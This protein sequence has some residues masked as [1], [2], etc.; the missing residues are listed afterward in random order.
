MNDIEKFAKKNELYAPKLC[1]KKE[2]SNYYSVRRSETP[3]CEVGLPVMIKET[4]G[5][6]EVVEGKEV[7]DILEEVNPYK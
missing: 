6:C 4:N 7:F 2:T 5:R 1:I 3:E